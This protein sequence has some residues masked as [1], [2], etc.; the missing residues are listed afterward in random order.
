MGINKN[1]NN[2]KFGEILI[3]NGFASENDIKDALKDQKEYLEKNK[4]HKKIGAI[5][6]EK[7]ILR[8]EDLR[9][10]LKEQEKTGGFMRYLAGIFN[11]TR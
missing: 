10:T 11:I 4:L 7:G 1:K 5:L 9:F 3:K 2:R 8:E 6:C